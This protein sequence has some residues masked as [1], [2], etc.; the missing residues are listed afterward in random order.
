MRATLGDRIVQNEIVQAITDHK[1]ILQ[2]AMQMATQAV[3]AAEVVKHNYWYR[4]INNRH[5]AF[6]RNISDP[7]IPHIYHNGYALPLARV[8]WWV[9][10]NCFTQSDVVA[11][12]H[13]WR[14]APVLDYQLNGNPDDF[15]SC[16]IK[17]EIGIDGFYE[18][19]G[20][21]LGAGGISGDLISGAAF[22]Q[23]PDDST[24][25]YESQY[26]RYLS[27]KNHDLRSVRSALL[28]PA[29]LL[30]VIFGIVRIFASFK[31]ADVVASC[32]P[33]RLNIAVISLTLVQIALVAFGGAI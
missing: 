33:K 1:L 18:K 32:L 9:S 28:R 31:L 29:V 16:R 17:R 3:L 8:R 14:L 24:S 11:D 26:Y 2:S 22:S 23:S 27:Q 5:L 10:S 25:A 19:I 15:A 4:L 13:G 21:K 12:I 30:F 6:G 20:A 7:I